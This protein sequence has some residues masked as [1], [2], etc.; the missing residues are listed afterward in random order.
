MSSNDFANIALNDT[1]SFFFQM[2]NM[3]HHL[4]DVLLL[5]FIPIRIL[6]IIFMICFWTFTSISWILRSRSVFYFTLRNSLGLSFLVLLDIFFYFL[7]LLYYSQN[8]LRNYVTLMKVF[9]LQQAVRMR[10]DCNE[11]YELIMHYVMR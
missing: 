5:S 7:L 2:Q 6:S 1:I 11:R 10:L 8:I 4:W 3:F 9:C